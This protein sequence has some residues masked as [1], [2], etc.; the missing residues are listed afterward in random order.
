M[1]DLLD[2][3]E[4][5]TVLKKCPEWEIEGKALTRTVEFEEFTEAIDF[6]NA[7]A[8]VAE[9]A[10]HHPDID[11]RYLRVTVRLSTHEVGGIS[12][13]DLEMAQRVDNLAD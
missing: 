11:I 9:E 5:A 6:V 4:L 8:E 7:L 1:S 2:E 3:N 13:A 10:H 12:D